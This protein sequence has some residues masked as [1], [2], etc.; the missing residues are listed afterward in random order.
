METTIEGITENLQENPAPR[1]KRD[2]TQSNK[3]KFSSFAFTACFFISFAVFIWFDLIDAKGGALFACI[4]GALIAFAD[5][6]Y[7]RQMDNTIDMMAKSLADSNQRVNDVSTEFVLP[8]GSPVKEISHVIAERDG[9]VRE[10][11]YRV[12]HGLLG[13]SCHT[14]RL[15]NS[16]STTASLAQEQR[17][18]A[19]K[20]FAASESNDTAVQNA[21]LHASDL[22]DV[23]TRQRGAAEASH[24]ELKIALQKVS[25]VEN[26]LRAFDET[27]TLLEAHSKDI[28][29]VVEIISTISDQTNLL[30]LNAAIEASSAGEAGKGFAVVA[31]EVRSLAVQVK[32]ATMGIAE[33][34]DK[35]SQLVGNTR[36][37][38]SD[39]KI[40]V[41]STSNAVRQASDRFESMV[42][43][44][45]Q[46]GD[47]IGQ[48]SDAIRSLS[49]TNSRIHKLVSE[50]NESCDQVSVRMTEGE[51]C[52]NSVSKGTERIQEFASSFQLG[53]D[54]LE[55]IVSALRDYR[56]RTSHILNDINT[57]NVD[58]ALLSTENLS[59]QK[60][61]IA[62]ALSSV[63]NDLKVSLSDMQYVSLN[64]LSRET[65]Y[66]LGEIPEKEE[67]IQRALQNERELLM[68]T[69]TYDN[70][71]IY[72]DLSLPIISHNRQ[73][74]ILRAGFCAEN[75][76]KSPQAA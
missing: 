44:Y 17:G 30:A 32:N 33:S 2:L 73:W 68:Q 71:K 8:E 16:L 67:I 5:A 59:P 57:D 7:I 11:V 27:V 46:M 48:T 49:N 75:I 66:R 62:Q 52:L 3:I 50:I 29:Q 69:F 64:S 76:L 37:S 22:D 61:A 31:T 6:L 39:I 35:M 9:H 65:E 47:R 36:S 13:V 53:S 18:L 4:A 25:D 72:F 14:A 45:M 42:Q 58:S 40:H 23:T 60:E 19:E 55:N 63:L 15:A 26:Q 43:E 21:L 74:G 10:M 51:N 70:G 28:G 56:D 41:D 38:T 1:V 20:V 12:R 54:S 24:N 34:I